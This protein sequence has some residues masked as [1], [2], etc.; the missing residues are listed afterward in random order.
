MPGDFSYCYNK[1]GVGMVTEFQKFATSF[2]REE[3][4]KGEERVSVKLAQMEK[5]ELLSEIVN[6]FCMN[7]NWKH[8]L[9]IW[10]E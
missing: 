4:R 7:H 1:G 5:G 3:W 8:F 6:I 9:T 2:S 10:V